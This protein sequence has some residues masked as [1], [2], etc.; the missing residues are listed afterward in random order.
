MPKLKGIS[1]VDTDD[2]HGWLVRHYLNSYTFSRFFSDLKHGS[3]EKAFI[4]ALMY[5]YDRESVFM[6]QKKTRSK[7]KNNQSGVSGVAK[8]KRFKHDGT[9]YFCYVAT[10]KSDDDIYR[11]KSFSSL[12]Y[13]TKEAFRLAVAYREKEQSVSEH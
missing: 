2:T 5:K 13:G 12:K 4:K 9:Y 11:T 3:R 10:W 8:V 1:R 6:S 7:Q